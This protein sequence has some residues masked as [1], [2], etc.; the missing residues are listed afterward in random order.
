VSASTGSATSSSG[1]GI[2]WGGLDPPP[3]RDASVRYSPRRGQ[4]LYV[5][6]ANPR[7]LE[8]SVDP[9]LDEASLRRFFAHLDVAACAFGH[10]HFPYRRRY[11]RML[12]ADVASAGIPRDGDVRPA[13]GVF[14]W[15]PRGWRVQIR[16]VRYSVRR[17]TQ[18][19][20]ARRVP[21]GPLLVHKLLEARY[22][23]HAALLEAARRHSGLPPAPFRVPHE[24]PDVRAPDD[25]AGFDTAG[26]LVTPPEGIPHRWNRRVDAG[27]G[28]RATERGAWLGRRRCRGARRRG[29]DPDLSMTFR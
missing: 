12:I 4:D 10:L 3:R 22:R 9:T 5:C 14:T 17:A 26:P 7:N 8:E 16:R 1:P 21:G 2:S 19:L 13:Y 15:T 23:H 24:A 25:S 20:T 11:G 6:H 28:R 29:A 18:A 27:D